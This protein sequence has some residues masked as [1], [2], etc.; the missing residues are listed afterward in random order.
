MASPINDLVIIGIDKDQERNAK[1]QKAGDPVRDNGG[2]VQVR[3]K[4]PGNYDQKF[5]WFEYIYAVNEPYGSCK[6]CRWAIQEEKLHK[7]SRM[8]KVISESTFISRSYTNWNN[9]YENIPRHAN[10]E[11]HKLC[12]D[13][14]SRHDSSNQS[15]VVYEI[16]AG[17]KAQK[18]ENSMA[19]KEVIRNLR[20]LVSQGL[21][22]PGKSDDTSNFH[23]LLDMSSVS[24]KLLST[25]LISDK[26]RKWISHQV[27]N[28]IIN[29]MSQT[30]LDKI[31]KEVVE[32]GFYGIMMD[33]TS[34]TANKE[35]V[36]LSVRFVYHKY[37]IH[38]AFVD[39][40]TVK[41][42]SGEALFSNLLDSLKRLGLDIKD[43]KGQRYDG[44]SSMSSIKK[45]LIAR[46][47]EVNKA[48]IN[49]HCYAHR[50]N[51]AL[52]V[53]V[54][55]IEDASI[56]HQLDNAFTAI[57][58]FAAFVRDSPKRMN[59]LESFIEQ[60]SRG[61]KSSARLRP[62]CPT[63]WCLRSPQLTRCT[64]YMSHV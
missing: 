30:V 56:R 15:T 27:E 34:D 10:S 28:E 11:I 42:T 1:R 29:I 2:E 12:L 18:Q 58:S 13:A 7:D 46:V 52:Q 4:T 64:I 14:R 47:Q 49:T 5:S 62:I 43:C 23:T 17:H 26:P 37:E 31:I 3:H 8:L 9:A 21:A 38:E 25:W 61:R 53:G 63:R 33:E 6:I 24:N 22:T 39:I 48:E 41:S 59:G 45:G 60:R 55:T 51:L 40:S 50:L 54:K 44:A 32:F 16:V 19:Y 20:W 35:Q 57:R 36:C